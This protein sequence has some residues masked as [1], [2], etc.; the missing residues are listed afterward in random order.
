MHSLKGVDMVDCIRILGI[1]SRGILA[2]AISLRQDTGPGWKPTGLRNFS[3]F[4]FHFS[5]MLYA[6]EKAN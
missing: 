2:S 3:A 4:Q 5:F 6:T 1:F